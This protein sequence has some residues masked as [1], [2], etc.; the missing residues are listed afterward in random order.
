MESLT[1]VYQHLQATRPGMQLSLINTRIMLEIGVNLKEIR[2][3]QDHDPGI[4]ARVRALLH[5]MGVT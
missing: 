4:L 2:P 3:E 5:E 1:G